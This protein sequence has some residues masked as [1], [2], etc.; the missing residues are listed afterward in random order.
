MFSA[1]NLQEITFSSFNTE[2]HA[3]KPGNVNPFSSAYGM[4]V[5]DFIHSARLVTPILCCPT[6]SV[7]ERILN[8]VQLIMQEIGCNT[9]LGMLLLFAPLIKAA[10]CDE[11]SL[12]LSLIRTL[13]E[14]G[15]DDT[16][17][18]FSAI[19]LANPGGLGQSKQYDVNQPPPNTNIQ[20]VMAEAAQRDTIAKQY[21]TGYADIFSLG[22]YCIKYFA[23]HWN[24][25]EWATVACYMTVLS[26]FPDSH[27]QRKFGVKVAEQVQLEAFSIAK[28]VKKYDNPEDAINML[29]RFDCRLKIAGLNPGTSADVTATSLLL[30]R[31]ISKA[32]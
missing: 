3:L 31:L 2:V 25:I 12:E 9:N 28:K 26:I 13:S 23:E 20:I 32:N 7:G 22:L 10:E 19:S 4:T 24:S 11:P 15:S 14:M 17:C 21:I 6:L 18:I 29:L 5:D 1:S 8:S 30:Y 16:R 27:I